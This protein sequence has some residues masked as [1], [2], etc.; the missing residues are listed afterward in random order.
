MSRHPDDDAEGMTAALQALTD[1]GN[2]NLAA[3]LEATAARLPH[4]PALRTTEC[5]LT[6]AELDERASTI[7]GGLMGVGVGAGDRVA[8]MAASSHIDFVATVYGAWKV[9]A[10]VVAVN[11]QLGPDEVRHHLE[12]A[13]PLVVV[14]DDGRPRTVVDEAVAA[15]TPSARGEDPLGVAARRPWVLPTGQ[16]RGTPQR[17]VR[18]GPLAD[19]TIFYTSGTTGVPKGATHTHRAHRAQLELVARRYGVE[20]DDVL[21]SV[22]P[23]YLLSILVLGPL[24]AT[25][26][27]ATCRLMPRYEP[28]A[29]ARH[30][31]EDRTTVVGA[32]IPMMFADLYHLPADQAAE[33]DLS[34]VRVASCGGSPMP[35]EIRNAFEARYDFRFVHAYGGTEG[36]AIV[37][38]DPLDRERKFDSVGVPLDHIAVTVEDPE[39]KELPPGEIGEICTAPRQDGPFAGWYEP[40][41]CYWG[42][43]EET[44][45]TLRGG[46]LHWGD[47][48]YVDDDGFV[49]LVDRKKDMIIRGGMNVYP[50]ELE[51]LLY[52]DPRIAECSVVGAHH[53]RYGEVPWAF[54]RAV[55]GASI[56]EDEVKALVAERS[57]RFKHLVGVTLVEE[58]PR[59]A[60][61]KVLKRE[62]RQQLP[63]L[64]P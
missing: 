61:G 33:V 59:N 25:H 24:L 34:S 62:L 45:D 60:L 19:A 53:R 10:I 22:L 23:I 58:F 38:T 56:T 8:L 47:L 52:A 30:V 15:L 63:A 9:G 64:G 14:A 18:L 54:V 20:E 29:F 55:P 3:R 35:P 46:R 39:G 40:M 4:K 7:A 26:V 6:Y 57:A 44:A 28:V 12:N 51:K 11:G 43:P 41:R 48:G 17:A 5:D 27:G 49:Y 2:W 31:K 37:S 13:E 32:T 16:A 50:K 21:C 36:P 1:G 42:M